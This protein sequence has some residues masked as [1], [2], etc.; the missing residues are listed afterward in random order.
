MTEFQKAMQE[1]ERLL[2][3]GEIDEGVF[4][5]YMYSE[6]QKAWKRAV[7]TACNLHDAKQLYLNDTGFT[8]TTTKGTINTAK[9][10]HY[11]TFDE[12]HAYIK[13]GN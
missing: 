11:H 8:P 5:D 4:I 3:T 10:I 1:P 9:I 6:V 13:G 2:R 7:N 12:A